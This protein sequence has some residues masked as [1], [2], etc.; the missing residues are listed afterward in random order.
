MN[1]IYFVKAQFAKK[2]RKE[3]R[4]KKER[5]DNQT[6]TLGNEDCED[7]R[8]VAA[9]GKWFIEENNQ[10]NIECAML[11]HDL[12]T[13]TIYL[14][15][16]HVRIRFNTNDHNLSA[17]GRQLFHMTLFFLLLLENETNCNICVLN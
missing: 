4:K 15:L 12:C 9:L 13:N 11:G 8:F 10:L 17:F 2:K 7:E 1:T 14:V 5:T 3:R 6:K 16:Q